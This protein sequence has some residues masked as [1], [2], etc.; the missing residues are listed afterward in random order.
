MRTIETM[1]WDVV[2]RLVSAEVS[3]Q[4]IMLLIDDERLLDILA[5]ATK[6]LMEVENSIAPQAE[7]RPVM[8][9]IMEEYERDQ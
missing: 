2:Y 4:R 5:D 1:R 8:V 6:K 9:H 3:L 7:E